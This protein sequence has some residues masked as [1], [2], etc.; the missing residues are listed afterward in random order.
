MVAK[1]QEA[2]RT[3][4]SRA[5]SVI[6]PGIGKISTELAKMAIDNPEL[7]AALAMGLAQVSQIPDEVKG[8]H[9]SN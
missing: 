4:G 2:L 6:A 8:L 7:T 1:I 5:R 9:F 3:T